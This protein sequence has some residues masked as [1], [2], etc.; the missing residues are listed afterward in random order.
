MWE[1]VRSRALGVRFRRQALV[2]GWIADF[3]CPSHGVVLEVDGGYHI[4]RTA[5]DQ[6]RDAVLANHGIKTLRFT[7]DEVLKNIS[8]VVDQ[9]KGV[10]AHSDA[11]A[12]ANAQHR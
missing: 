8:S 7:N 3:W 4:S 10:L 1:A 2:F 12:V 9:I 11:I 6:R 5:E